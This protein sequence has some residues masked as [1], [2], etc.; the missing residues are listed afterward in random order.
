MQHDGPISGRTATQTAPPLPGYPFQC[1]CADYFHYEDQTYLVIVDRYSNWP[2]VE[3]ADGGA[4]GLI[5]TLRL[6]FTTYSIPDELLS[7]GGPGLLSQPP[8]SF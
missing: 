1:I 7:D 4:I 5:K 2:I 3:R 8:G 6:T